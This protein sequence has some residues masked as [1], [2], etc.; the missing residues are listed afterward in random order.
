MVLIDDSLWSGRLADETVQDSSTVAIRSVNEKIAED[1]DVYS[2]LVPIHDGMT[3]AVKKRQRKRIRSFATTTSE[4][5]EKADAETTIHPLAGKIISFEGNI[6]CGKT[7]LL[8]KISK[9]GP[10]SHQLLM[11]IFY[12]NPIEAYLRLFYEDPER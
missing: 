4:S 2:S 6:G 3:V 12:E 7:T 8:K 9:D 1:P 11:Q 5:G 10:L